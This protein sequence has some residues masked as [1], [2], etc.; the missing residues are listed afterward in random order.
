MAWHRFESVRRPRLKPLQRQHLLARYHRG[1]LTQREFAAREGIG[2]STL[3]KWLQQERG[4]S[5]APVGF[6]EV[7]LPD[8]SGRWALEIVHPQGWTV[9]LAEI[10][11]AASLSQLLR[12]LPC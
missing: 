12:A 10:S 3:V 11:D 9:R 2:L 6:Q 8:S 1:Q 5:A 7:A 4:G